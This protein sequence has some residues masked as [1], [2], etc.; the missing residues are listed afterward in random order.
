M[1]HNYVTKRPRSQRTDTAVES[2]VEVTA[3]VRV[4]P[5]EWLA[6]A[7]YTHATVVWIETI[8]FSVT[9]DHVSAPAERI[10]RITD[11][12]YHGDRAHVIALDRADVRTMP[13]VILDFIE[14]GRW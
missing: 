7:I 2:N 9:H 10:V 8:A 4:K 6:T 13:R 11:G 1:V 12:D 14:A 3:I 5:F